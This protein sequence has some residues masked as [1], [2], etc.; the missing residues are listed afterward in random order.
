MPG[1]HRPAPARWWWCS[2]WPSV[3]SLV[4]GVQDPYVAEQCRRTA[5]TDG[6][7]LSGLRLAA[8]ERP[9]EHPGAGPADRLHGPPELRRRRLVRRVADLAGERAVP[10]RE[11]PLAGELEVEALHVDRPRLVADDVQPAFDP[12]DQVVRG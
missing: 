7:H 2:T 9:A 8:V 12:P 5:V 11:E 10:D 3:G 4:V 1:R 6:G